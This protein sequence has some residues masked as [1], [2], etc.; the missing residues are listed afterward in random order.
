MITWYR[1]LHRQVSLLL[2]NGHPDA[3]NY[4]VGFV[5]QQ[6]SFVAE[7]FDA[8]EVTRVTLLQL[9]VSTILGGSKARKAFMDEIK[10]LTSWD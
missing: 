1:G 9:A 3:W 8:A 2:A 10:F 7:R 4:P 6:A 5:Y